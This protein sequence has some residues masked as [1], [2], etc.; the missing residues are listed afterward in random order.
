MTKEEREQVVKLL[1]STAGSKDT[2]YERADR[3][4]VS[5]DI[6]DMASDAKDAVRDASDWFDWNDDSHYD[7]LCL[8]AA[9]RIERG[10]WP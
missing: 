10:E 7:R 3:L 5:P 8:E 1:R 4:G 2:V 6:A 9:D